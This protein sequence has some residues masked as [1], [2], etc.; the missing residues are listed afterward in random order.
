VKQAVAIV[1]ALR[2]FR[3]LRTGRKMDITAPIQPPERKRRRRRGFRSAAT[4]DHGV[5]KAPDR[6]VQGEPSRRE[7]HHRRLR[8]GCWGVSSAGSELN[9]RWVISGNDVRPASCPFFP[10]KQTFVSAEHVWF[11]PRA[12][13]MFPPAPRRSGQPRRAKM[14]RFYLLP[15]LVAGSRLASRRLAAG[16]GTFAGRSP[17]GGERLVHHCKRLRIVHVQLRIS[18]SSP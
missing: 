14:E 1:L 3:T 11:V 18:R 13:L 5:P 12:V 16:G 17:N 8:L 6:T 9:V 15:G 7:Q 10:S 2:T 4:A